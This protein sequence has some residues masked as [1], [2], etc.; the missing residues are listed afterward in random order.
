MHACLIGDKGWR[1]LQVIMVIQKKQWKYG[2]Q[3]LQGWGGEVKNHP[4]LGVI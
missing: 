3:W 1:G 2:P 4:I